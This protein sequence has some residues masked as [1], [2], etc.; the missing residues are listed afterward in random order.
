MLKKGELSTE[1]LLEL[2]LAVAAVLIVTFLLYN[3]VSSHYDKNEKIADT[4]FDLLVDEIAF[5]DKG[6]IGSF[7]MWQ[8]SDGDSVYFL[9]YFQNQSAYGTPTKFSSL[10]ANLNHICICY[11]KDSDSVCNSCV[12]LKYPV[13]FSDTVGVYSE[14]A[15]ESKKKIDIKFEGDHYL[16]SILDE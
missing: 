6:F 7:S 8:H 2:I 12:D 5:A 10:G 1:E 9:V 4:Y 3:L 15:I 14:R 13:M 16:F 11:L